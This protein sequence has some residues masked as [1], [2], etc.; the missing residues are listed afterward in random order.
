[1]L[2]KSS[3]HY[4]LP[5]AEEFDIKPQLVEDVV[6]F[7]YSK[8]RLALVNLDHFAIKAENLGTFNA[9]KKELP[10]LYAKYTNHL[11][12]LKTETF[13]QMQTKKEVERKLDRVSKLQKL[14][15]EES[16]RKQEFF[17]TKNY[18]KNKSR[19]NLGK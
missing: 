12:V 13:R 1:M 18:E 8:L 15:S 2:P 7:Y 17:K 6:A 4:I 16:K 11:S 3:K 10:K 9:K 14:I 5:T 19:K